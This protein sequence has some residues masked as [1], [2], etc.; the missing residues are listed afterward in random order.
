METGFMTRFAAL[1]ACL[2]LTACASQDHSLYHWNGYQEQIYEGFQIESGNTS[3]DK[4]LQKLQEEQQ[5]A[6]AKNKPLPP[7]YQAHM[8]FLYFQTGQADKAVMAF[9]AEKKQFPESTVYMDLVLGKL[10]Q[11]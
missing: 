9:E 11:K 5:K 7:G 3:P 10:R 4:Q 6:V 8:G 2:L 1:A